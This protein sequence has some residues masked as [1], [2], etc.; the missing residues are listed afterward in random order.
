MRTSGPLGSGTGRSAHPGERGRGHR[1]GSLVGV[2][3]ARPRIAPVAFDDDVGL[4]AGRVAV[5]VDE[6]AHALG[7]GPVD[8]STPGTLAPLAPDC[9]GVWLPAMTR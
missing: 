7:V 3:V 8:L 2:Q 6:L 5:L 4:G 1:L 9:L